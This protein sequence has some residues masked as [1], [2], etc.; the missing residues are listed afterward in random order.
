VNREPKTTSN[1]P[2]RPTLAYRLAS[3]IDGKLICAFQADMLINDQDMRV[4]KQVGYA[5]SSGIS[6]IA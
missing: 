2:F 5:T 6:F 1:T 4:K 3:S